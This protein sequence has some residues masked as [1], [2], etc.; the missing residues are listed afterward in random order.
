MKIKVTEERECCSYQDLIKYNGTP[1][2]EKVKFCKYCG[3]LHILEYFTDAAGD[4][5]SEYK[6][7][8]IFEDLRGQ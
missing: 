4:R 8:K 1:K 5:D 7:I 2:L 3:Q 6:K